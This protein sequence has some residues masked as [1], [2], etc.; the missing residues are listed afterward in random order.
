[1]LLIDPLLPATQHRPG[2]QFPKNLQFLP[3]F[4]CHLSFS[5]EEP[6]KPKQSADDRIRPLQ[7]KS[8]AKSF[9][10]KIE[11]SILIQENC[12]GNEFMRFLERAQIPALVMARD[13]RSNP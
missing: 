3:R 7:V 5:P 8:P 9:I 13:Q 10:L 4:A 1:M 12:E 11:F 2:A 6:R